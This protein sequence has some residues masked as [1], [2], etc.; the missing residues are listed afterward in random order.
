ME[1]FTKDIFQGTFEFNPRSMAARQVHMQR[2]GDL[3]ALAGEEEEENAEELRKAMMKQ[4]LTAGDAESILG[5]FL[6]GRC[7][8]GGV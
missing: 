8:V 6:G 7:Y 2:I 4:T 3:S 5:R 1:I